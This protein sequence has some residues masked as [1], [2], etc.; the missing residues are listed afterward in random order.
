[1]LNGTAGTAPLAAIASISQDQCFRQLA[2]PPALSSFSP[3]VFDCY[4]PL[5][6]PPTA[7]HRPALPMP[8]CPP[9][10]QEERQ[11][12]LALAPYLVTAP[13]RGVIGNSRYAQ[14]LRAEIV[15]ASRDKDR[16]VEPGY[17][18]YV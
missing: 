1:M 8:L 6:S 10:C 15:E 13:K 12:Q 7:L 11:R 9:P 3:R 16:F 14:R 18:G 2:C 5:Q 4:D 17:V